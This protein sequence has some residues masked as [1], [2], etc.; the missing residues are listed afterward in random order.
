MARTNMIL[1][2]DVI[3]RSH[4]SIRTIFDFIVIANQQER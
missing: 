1:D 2:L 4:N 3:I